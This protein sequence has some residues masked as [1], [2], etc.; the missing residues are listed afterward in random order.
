M[1]VLDDIAAEKQRLTDRL[2]RVDAER[3]R[4]AQQLAELD[5]AERVLLRMTP[6]APRRGSPG[7]RAEAV[8]A[9]KPALSRRGRRAR[10]AD[11]TEWAP[12]PRRG[13]GRG[14]RRTR[15]KRALGLGDATLQAVQALG[16]NAAAQQ[17]R[18]YLAEHFG[19]RVRPNHLGMALQRHRRAGRLQ[20]DDGRWSAVLAETGP[21]SRDQETAHSRSEAAESVE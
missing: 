17:I 21:Q 6:G 7:R 11:A 4:L 19:L 10:Q 16:N 5:A 9:A 12:A 20:E 18:D 14:G 15:Q 1:P 13:A 8:E 2:A 3:E